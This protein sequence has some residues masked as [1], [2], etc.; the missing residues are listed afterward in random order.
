MFNPIYQI[1]FNSLFLVVLSL[2]F[3][4][5]KSPDILTRFVDNH[6]ILVESKME[7]SPKL[8]LDLR[9]GYSRQKAIYFS[10]LIMDSLDIGLSGYHAAIRHIPKI[11]SLRKVALSGE[12]FEYFIEKKEKMNVRENYFSTSYE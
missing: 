1:F 12:E 4:E 5:C 3:A 2:N 8:W 11:D 6:L 10:N 9:E 7:D